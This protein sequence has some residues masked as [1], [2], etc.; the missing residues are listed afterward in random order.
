M[1]TTGDLLYDTTLERGESASEERNAR[2]TWID[3]HAGELV[4][5]LPRELNGRVGLVLAENVDGK[6]A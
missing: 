2:F 5:A 4:V 3:R 6:A 1:R